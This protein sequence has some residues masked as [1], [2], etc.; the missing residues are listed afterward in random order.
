M[1]ALVAVRG[2]EQSG[3]GGGVPVVPAKFSRYVDRAHSTSDIGNFAVDKTNKKVLP[4]YNGSGGMC[5]LLWWHSL[6]G[7]VCCV[8]VCV[9]VSGYLKVAFSVLLNILFWH[10]E[11]SKHRQWMLP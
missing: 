7:C 6:E 4:V 1:A 8:C 9:C 2:K 5:A 10:Q 3:L 11:P